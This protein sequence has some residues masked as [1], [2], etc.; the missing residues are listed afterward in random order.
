MEINGIN[1]MKMA[2]LATGLDTETMVK[3]MAALSKNR[4]NIEQQKYDALVLKQNSYRTII[5]SI[6]EFKDTYF[7]MLNPKTNLASSSLFGAR[8]A[9]SSSSSIKVSAMANAD[10]GDF[11]VNEV[12]Q[13][14]EKAQISGSSDTIKTDVMLNF[15]DASAEDVGKTYTVRISL[16][17]NEKDATFT[18]GATAEETKNSFIDA[19]NKAYSGKTNPSDG[20]KMQ[21]F[22]YTDG[23]LS[24]VDNENADYKHTFSI[25]LPLDSTTQTNNEILNTLGIDGSVSTKIKTGTALC[26][27]NFAT[28]LK[29]KGYEF[30]I[31]GENFV[32]SEKD[33]ISKIMNEINSSDAGVKMSFNSFDNS[34]SLE[35]NKTGSGASIEVKQISGNL[36][37]SLFGDN[38]GISEPTGSYVSSDILLD[39]TFVGGEVEDGKGFGFKSTDSEGNKINVG[40]TGNAF[41]LV[42]QSFEI[43]V[44]DKTEKI[45]LWQYNK[46]GIKVN[47]ESSSAVTSLINDELELAFGQDAPTISFNSQTGKFSLDAQNSGDVITIEAPTSEGSEKL[48]TALG[49]TGDNSTNQIDTS[50]V[51]IQS[52]TSTPIGAGATLDFG[53]GIQVTVTADT[54]IDELEVASQG[55]FVFENGMV[56]IKGLDYANSS[57]DAKTMLASIFGKGYNYPGTP[58][59]EVE[60][61]ETNI[62]SGKDA[63]IKV[64]DNIIINNTNSFDINGVIVDISNAQ[65]GDSAD[66]S[67]ASD[68]ES[69]AEAITKFVE[70]YNALTESLRKEISFKHPKGEEYLPL[71]DEQKEEMS[72]KEIE[73]WEEKTKQGLLYQDDTINRFLSDIR[74]AVSGGNNVLQLSR[75]GI[76]VSNQW[77]DYGKLEID[78]TKLKTALEENLTDIQKF[79]TD[80]EDGFSKTVKETLDSYVSTTGIKGQLVS[81]AGM[82]NTSTVN[83][84]QISRELESYQSRIDSLQD[85]Y[86]NELDRYWKQFTA[87]EKLT[88]E[89]NSQSQWLAQQFA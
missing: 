33:S 69:A 47:Y 7:D 85:R 36:L 35:S 24:Y 2:G 86:D 37:N 8:T 19:L 49:F 44:N 14:A 43:T 5:D 67:S 54:T 66:I 83:D 9:I 68:T 88:Q 89:M 10:L 4:L 28:E 72:E 51:T 30:E 74:N 38:V 21:Y 87:L 40:A 79:F 17:G 25:D 76:T 26:N 77:Q 57:E 80:A 73:K 46:S 1:S 41:E 84:S 34:F 71:T 3:Q 53:D 29:G 42:N 70:D 15:S 6:T 64:E 81:I 39:T 13:K 20:T 22:E 32:F 50:K 52:L 12:I 61:M 78:E 59:I 56:S 27:V 60:D 65:E 31:N 45:T 18:V 48:V 82:E 58:P 16:N 63:V 11:T 23:N 75:I 62:I 55:R